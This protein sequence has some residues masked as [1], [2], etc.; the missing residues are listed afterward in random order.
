MKSQ[1]IWPRY[2]Q[3]SFVA[4][5]ALKADERPLNVNPGKLC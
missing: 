5:T 1:E 2:S 4:R 3:G